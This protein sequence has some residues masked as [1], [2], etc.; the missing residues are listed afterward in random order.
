MAR[1][2]LAVNLKKQIDKGVAE[3]A[4]ILLNGEQKSL[5]V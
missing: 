2:D 1:R 4:K 3:G 5:K